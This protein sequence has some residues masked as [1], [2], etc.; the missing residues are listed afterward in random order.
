MFLFVVKNRSFFVIKY[1]LSVKLLFQI[2]ISTRFFYKIFAVVSKFVSFLI[3]YI[4]EVRMS[5]K[6]IIVVLEMLYRMRKFF[7]ENSHTIVKCDPKQKSGAKLMTSTVRGKKRL[8]FS[9]NRS[10][11]TGPAISDFYTHPFRIE[12]KTKKMNKEK[13][14]RRRYIA[15]II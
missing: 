5:V 9:A 8:S 12:N 6:H 11:D 7:L 13:R 3:F 15:G 10:V 1:I 2:K 4:E 14:T